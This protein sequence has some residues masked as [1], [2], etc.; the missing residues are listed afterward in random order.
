MCSRPHQVLKPIM[1]SSLSNLSS[2]QVIQTP[3]LCYY[4]QHRDTAQNISQNLGTFTCTHWEC[5]YW[6][7]SIFFWRDKVCRFL[8]MLCPNICYWE[9]QNSIPYNH[10]TNR[11]CGTMLN[12]IK[13]LRW[14]GTMYSLTSSFNLGPSW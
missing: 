12:V 8:Y 13:N 2:S 5:C 4:G 1:D 10:F 6:I 9:N 14:H 7:V 11:P 3:P